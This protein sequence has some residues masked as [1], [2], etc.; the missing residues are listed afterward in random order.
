[1]YID[2]FYVT[3]DLCDILQ[4]NFRRDISID[5]IEMLPIFKTGQIVGIR[6]SLSLAGGFFLRSTNFETERKF[7][8]S[9]FNT[10]GILSLLRHSFKIWPVFRSRISF[11]I[12]IHIMEFN[13]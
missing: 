9:K 2:N 8:S 12:I 1:M 7:F 3:C 4:M 6:I 11:Q 5:I 10:G 13:K